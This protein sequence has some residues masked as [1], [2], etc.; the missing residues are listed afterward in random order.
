ML[1]SNE[2]KEI[3]YLSHCFIGK[4]HDYSMLKKEFPP[5]KNWF[6]KFRIRVDLG[7]LGIEKDYMAKEISIPHKKKKKQELSDL[8]KLSNKDKAKSRIKVEH[9]ISG[10]KRY[11]ILSDRLRIHDFYLYNDVIEVCAGLWNFYLKN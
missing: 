2:K 9:S 10:M 4:T 11:K 5:K 3:L 7:Y 8:E 1:I 6:K